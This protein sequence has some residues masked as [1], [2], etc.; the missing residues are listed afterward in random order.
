M[1]FDVFQEFFTIVCSQL[2]APIDLFSGDPFSPFILV[3][4]IVDRFG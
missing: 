1:F 2:A 4:E 3:T